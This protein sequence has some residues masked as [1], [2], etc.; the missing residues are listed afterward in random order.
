M[1]E[2]TGEGTNEEPPDR[3]I[4]VN[5]KEDPEEFFG[6]DFLFVLFWGGGF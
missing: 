2:W 1:D 5:L 6:L 3:W 4:H